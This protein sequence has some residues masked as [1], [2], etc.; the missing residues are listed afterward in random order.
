MS[1][2]GH[3]TERELRCGPVS[4]VGRLAEA[5]NVALL[6]RA[7]Q[8][9]AVYKPVAGERQLWDFPHGALAHREVAAALVSRLGGWPYICETVLRDG[10]LGPG[11]FQRWVTELPDASGLIDPASH[12]TGLVGLFPSR[13]V[14]NGWFPVL[15]GQGY[16]GRAVVVAHADDDDL[17]SVAVLDA[18]LNNGDRKGS[19]LLRGAEGRIWGIDH[20]VSLHEQDKLRTVLWGW[21]GTPLPAR[22]RD[23]LDRL[24]T[25]LPGAAKELAPLL[26]GAELEA[27]TQRVDALRARGT[28]PS[29]SGG[30]PSVPWPPL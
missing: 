2:D 26:T 6:V 30:W 8:V 19:H 4:V 11:S 10:P 18:V 9:H 22:E 29:S 20:G 3:A 16:D 23:R 14:P 25:D 1:T 21:A 17:R 27:L 15:S 13:R 5:S 28:Y 7:G 12:E 24:A